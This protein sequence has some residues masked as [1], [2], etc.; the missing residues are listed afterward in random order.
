MLLQ[1]ALSDLASD[2]KG[3]DRT[4]LLISRLV[5]MHWE[6]KEFHRIKEEYKTKFRSSLEDDVEKYVR[7][8]DT[9]DACLGLCEV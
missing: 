2:G 1:H 9:R 3:Q 6:K 8:Q 4:E 5:R 7:N